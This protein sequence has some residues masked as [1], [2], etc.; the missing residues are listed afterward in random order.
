MSPSAVSITRHAVTMTKMKAS[1]NVAPQPWSTTR[2]TREQ[3]A[4]TELD[5]VG[6]VAGVV[7]AISLA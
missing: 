4:T 3:R 7:A 1:R 5:L 2:A 6:R